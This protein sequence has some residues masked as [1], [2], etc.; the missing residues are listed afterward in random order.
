MKKALKKILFYSKT[1]HQSASNADAIFV[2]NVD[3]ASD[4]TV[5][6]DGDDDG[7]SDEDS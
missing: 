5:G 2:E 1:N 3:D 7:V 4:D 6:G